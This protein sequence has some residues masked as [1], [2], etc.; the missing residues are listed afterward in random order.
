MTIKLTQR[1]EEVMYWVQQ[2]ATNKDI[3]ERL[4]ITVA[5]VKL[6]TTL[7][8]KKYGVQR[9]IQLILASTKNQPINLIPIDIEQK[10]VMWI[11]ENAMAITGLSTKAIDGWTPLYKKL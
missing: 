8:M 3:A 5:T 6:H 1:Q 11:N 10:P 9:R 7:I 4:N 2:G